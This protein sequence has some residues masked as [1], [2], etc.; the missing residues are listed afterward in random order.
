MRISWFIKGARILIRGIHMTEKTH[1][2]PV[3]LHEIVQALSLHLDACVIDC[4]LGGGGH[5]QEIM[6]HLG[7]QGRYVGID[8][9]PRAL[10]RVQDVLLEK[11]FPC[12]IDYVVG[13]FGSLAEIV[14]PLNLE[15]VDAILF[16]L[17]WSSDQIIDAEIGMSFLHDAPL[18]ML[19]KREKQPG[20]IDAY[21]I[22][23]TWSEESLA[24][25]LYV[26][27]DE[28]RSRVIARVIVEE[29][30]KNPIRTTLELAQCIEKRF[31]KGKRHP[32]TKTFQALRIAVNNEYQV[33]KDGL[34][35]AIQLLSPGG[36]CAVL[37][38][39]SGEDRIVKHVFRD[40]AQQGIIKL[41]IKKPIVPPFSEIQ[42]NPR[43]RSA[44]LRVIQK[45]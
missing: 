43:A 3:L 28:H 24:D 14:Q 42:L 4:T 2:I 15:R 35:Q 39:H 1:H 33:L 27:G 45:I 30:K 26:Y 36:H 8:Q 10:Q 9:D 38:F 5:A 22:I 34:D 21:D 11:K 6:K 13:N 31:G 29:R 7:K 41:V 32:A 16:D 20:D 19:L 12:R 17:G 18:S 25:V 44:K 23:N 37:S 40:Y